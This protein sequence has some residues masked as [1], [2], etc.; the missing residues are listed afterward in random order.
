MPKS[1]K[2]KRNVFKK[3]SW[4]IDG[5]PQPWITKAE[6]MDAA[7]TLDIEGRS[8]MTKFELYYTL[9]GRSP[10]QWR[11]GF[12]GNVPLKRRAFY[13]KKPS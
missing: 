6:L 7:Q 5:G 13:C 8:R 9:G 11:G 12:R 1:S 2:R 4:K 3:T 10:P